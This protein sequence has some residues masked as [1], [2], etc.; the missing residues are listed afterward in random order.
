MFVAGFMG[1]P[2]MNFIPGNL[3]KVDGAPAV[4][5][6]LAGGGTA[7]LA[8]AQE[9]GSWPGDGE[10]VLGVRPEYLFRY[11]ENSKARSPLLSARRESYAP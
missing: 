3:V 10:V 5:V 7:T 6:A 1:S 8:L 11:N 9:A 4:A 2:S